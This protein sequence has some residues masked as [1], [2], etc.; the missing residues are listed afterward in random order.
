M[1]AIRSYSNRPHAH[2][3]GTH[4]PLKI[5]AARQVGHIDMSAV[6]PP[7]KARKR[8][9]AFRDTQLARALAGNRGAHKT[10]G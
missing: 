8:S 7:R 2:A 3:S 5:I 1:A 10:G 9:L 6:E 4:T